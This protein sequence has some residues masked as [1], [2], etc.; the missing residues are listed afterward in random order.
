MQFPAAPFGAYL[1]RTRLSTSKLNGKLQR[2]I[3]T[4]NKD[5]CPRAV[6]FYGGNRVVTARACTDAIRLHRRRMDRFRQGMNIDL[7]AGIVW[8]LEG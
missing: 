1:M 3:V 6:P 5:D 4:L 7:I 2:V 8:L